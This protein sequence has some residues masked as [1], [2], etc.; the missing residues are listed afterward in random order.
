M[1]ILL[2][3]DQKL[4]LLT[5]CKYLV[6]LGHT[7]KKAT[8]MS[9]GIIIYDK[10]R[11]DLVITDIDMPV[12]PN[13]NFE[14]R[15]LDYIKMKAGLEVI[16]HIRII[17][18]EPT[19]VV[20]LSGNSNSEMIR[21]AFDL[22][23]NEYLVKPLT[24]K[25][26]G[27]CLDKVLGLNSSKNEVDLGVIEK[28]CIGIVIPFGLNSFAAA[29]DQ[30]IDFMSCNS[31]VHLYLVGCTNSKPLAA[32]SQKITSDQKQ[33]I[34]ILNF[35]DEISK[36][37][38][39]RLGMLHLELQHQFEYIVY[40]DGNSLQLTNFKK[41]MQNITHSTSPGIVIAAREKLSCRL[42][43]FDM[44]RFMRQQR[45]KHLL[46]NTP[47][48]DFPVGMAAF[49]TKF[50]APIFTRIFKSE[51]KLESEII[52]RIKEVFKQDGNN[53]LINNFIIY[54]D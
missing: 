20:V 3:D 44:Q 37:Q 40:M 19:P 1:K 11:P 29:H 14:L 31:N 54:N 24:L 50:V 47:P 45:L 43:G 25:E 48:S 27:V 2:I 49:N 38:A 6:C 10:F 9:D 28:S 4:V 32:L 22:G 41:F 42:F 30:I 39:I 18:K 7:V 34:S 16:K 12:I 26:M 52:E 35:D 53:D 46:K 17:R 51:S 33:R 15:F 13:S 23:V 21:E 8:N 5:V 36:P